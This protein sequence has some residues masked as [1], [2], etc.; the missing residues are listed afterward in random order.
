[1][2]L[3]LRLILGDQLNP[4]HSWFAT[5]NPEVVY[6]L[7]EVTQETGYVRHHVQKVVVFFAAMR[8]FA[9]D[10]RAQGHVVRYLRLGDPA[11]QQNFGDNV[12]ALV[13]ELDCQRLEYQLPDEYRLDVYLRQLAASLPIATQAVDSEHFLTHRLAVREVFK[14]KKMYLL[15]TFYRQMRQKHQ[16]LLDDQGQPV[17]GRWNF[18]AENRKKFDGKANVPSQPSFFSPQK[19]KLVEEIYQEITQVGVETIGR[20][21]VAQFDWYFTVADAR[22]Q[23]DFFVKRCLPH[24]G[25]YEDAMDTRFE[26]LFHSRL[27]FALNVKLLHPLEVV[28]A[29]IGEWQRRPSEI[30]LPQIEGFVRQIVGWREYMRGIYWDKMPGFA[31]LNFFD[32]RRPLPSWYWTGE[33][34]MNCLRHAIGQSLDRAYA[35]HIQRLMVTGAFANLAGIH[36]DELDAWYLGIY[37]DAIEWVEITNTRGMS[38]FADGGIVGTKPYVGSANYI[39]K[40][41]NYCQSCAYDK[42]KKHGAGAC[43]FNSLYW[44]FYDRHRD[45]LANNPRIGM[46]YVTWDK[47]PPVEKAK[48]LAQAEQYLAQIEEL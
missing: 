17:G 2:S 8:S 20:I 5:P 38:Q 31:L 16:L 7:M 23:L 37:A 30:S 13:A 11:N 6:V 26:V 15:E 14:G 44:H 36:P 40:M 27:S 42:D 34:K 10:L 39:N 24:F 35:H 9:A 47:Q 41:S 19:Q 1:M 22:Q 25:T 21:D 33:V 18:D 3:T 32:H 45:K 28:Q 48:I 12:R 4:R 46:A 29:A 43:P